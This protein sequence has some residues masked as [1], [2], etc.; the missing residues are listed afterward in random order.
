MFTDE[1]K[2]HEQDRKDERG[3]CDHEFDHYQINGDSILTCCFCRET[4]V[5]GI[6]K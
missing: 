4:Y 6:R 2:A 3:N 1:N 5:N